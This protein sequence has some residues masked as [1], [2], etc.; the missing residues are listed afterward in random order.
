[1][2]CA[3]LPCRL[4]PW[5]YALKG[6]RLLP[7]RL[8]GRS[9]SP[10]PD[11]R[12]TPHQR[13][14]SGAPNVGRIRVVS[15]PTTTESDEVSASGQPGLAACGQFPLAA[16]RQAAAAPWSGCAMLAR[17]ILPWSTRARMVG[18]VAALTSQ[19]RA[20]CQPA[21]HPGGIV[22]TTQICALQPATSDNRTA[23]HSGGSGSLWEPRSTTMGDCEGHLRVEL[24][25]GDTN[26]GCF[27]SGVQ[28]PVPDGDD[29]VRVAD[30]QGAGEVDGVRASECVHAGQLAGVL[31]HGCCEFDRARGSPVAVP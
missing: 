4:C 11:Q 13:N 1:M 26:T 27:G 18:P 3:G 29:K 20:S 24:R 28:T 15:Q 22:Q 16:G 5:G 31:L 25:W 21:D 12:R 14:R 23:A 7:S 9:T 6:I 30:G 2:N 19:N 10:W 17:D 8:A